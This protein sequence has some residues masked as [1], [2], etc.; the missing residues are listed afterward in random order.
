MMKDKTKRRI[1]AGGFV[2]FLLYL[3]ALV[4]FLF[5]SEELGRAAAGRTYSYNLKPFKEI[6]RFWNNRESL[7]MLAVVLN[8]AGNVMAFM[9]FGAILP[10]LSRPARGAFQITMLSL[11]FSFLIE[12]FQL[13]LR[14]GSFD[15]DD[16]IL[17]TLGGFLGY[18]VFAVCD[19][20]RRKHY[21]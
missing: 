1:K 11:E 15:V 5:F 19:K 12:C 3:M 20:M 2:L 10:V 21:G 4:Y 7:G 9:P 13:M 18:L 14:V 8:L 17:N 6:L 16:M